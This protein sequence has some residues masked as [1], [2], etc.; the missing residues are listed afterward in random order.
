MLKHTKLIRK[1]LR[2][3]NKMS[4]IANLKDK[5]ELPVIITDH[6][7]IVIYVNSVFEATFGW[8]YS[9]IIGQTLALILPTYFQDAHHLGFS[10]FSATGVS[11]IRLFRTKRVL[12][13][14]NN[15]L[16]TLPE[17]R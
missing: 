5:S 12:N 17:I 10:R 13:L 15:Q 4:A 3:R 7:G 1:L 6:Q 14:L 11:T 8:N 16:E 9:D 2:I